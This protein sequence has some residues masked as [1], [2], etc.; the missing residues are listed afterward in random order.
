MKCQLLPDPK[1]LCLTGRQ[2]RGGPALISRSSGRDTRRTRTFFPQPMGIRVEGANVPTSPWHSHLQTDKLKEID[3][4][5]K[6]FAA[7]AHIFLSHRSDKMTQ[8]IHPAIHTAEGIDDNNTNSS[9][10]L[11]SPYVCCLHNRSA[12]RAGALGEN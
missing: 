3:G 12:Y 6:Q 2:R 5:R 11:S 8:S 1:L 7:R 4:N 10:C 9:S